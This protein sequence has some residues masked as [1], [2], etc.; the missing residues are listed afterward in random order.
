MTY[1]ELLYSFDDLCEQLS[2]RDPR[3]YDRTLYRLHRRLRGL[4]AETQRD[5]FRSIRR[6]WP[7][8]LDPECSE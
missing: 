5:L 2:R 7:L 8:A 6:R 4:A 3:N 1:Y